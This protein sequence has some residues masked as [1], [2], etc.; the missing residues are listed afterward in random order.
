[1]VRTLFGPVAIQL[2]LSF[3]AF[4]SNPPDLS[5]DGRKGTLRA[6]ISGSY[7]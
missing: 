6:D 1:M 4:P 7:C 5:L 3:H 2:R